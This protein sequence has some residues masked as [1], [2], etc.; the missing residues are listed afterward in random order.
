MHITDSAEATTVALR[1]SEA[2]A[3]EAALGLVSSQQQVRREFQQ[4]LVLMRLARMQQG[5]RLSARL[6]DEL[7]L[8]SSKGRRAAM[9]TLTYRP[10]ADWAALHMSRFVDALLKWAGRRGVTVPYVWVAELQE[11][12]AVHYHMILWLPRGFTIP[13]PDK[14]GWW[15]HGSSRVEWARRA[16]SYITKYASKGGDRVSFPRGLRLWSAG[17]LGKDAREYRAWL[18]LPGWLRKATGERARIAKRPGGFYVAQETGEV[19]QSPW[20]FVRIINSA[21]VAVAALFR[22]RSNGAV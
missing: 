2:S 20:E 22:E 17:G 14:Q 15:P 1:A 6:I 11:R 9:V 18:R 8:S 12:G 7:T 13:K 16:V 5:V 4:S 3:D 10:D 21:G 19:F